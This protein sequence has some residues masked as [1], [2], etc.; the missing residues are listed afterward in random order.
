[1]LSVWK[2]GGFSINVVLLETLAKSENEK[3]TCHFVTIGKKNRGAQ[4]IC[5]NLIVNFFFYNNSH[6]SSDSKILDLLCK[7]IK[8]I[9]VVWFTPNITSAKNHLL[10]KHVFGEQR[11]AF[12]VH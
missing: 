12:N 11:S 8:L 9:F 10:E 3:Q 7:C 1:M 6:P 4:N 2:I 5:K